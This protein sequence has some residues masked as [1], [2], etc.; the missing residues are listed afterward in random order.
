[1]WGVAKCT[2]M[3]LF[4]YLKQSTATRPVARAGLLR[5]MSLLITYTY[6]VRRRIAVPCCHCQT[7]TDQL[8]KNLHILAVTSLHRTR[9]LTMLVML[10]CNHN[11]SVAAGLHQPIFDPPT[12]TLHLK[13]S[14]LGSQRSLSLD[15]WF[16][17]LV[18][19]CT[20]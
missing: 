2:I 15:A 12:H 14:Q 19:S 3:V 13:L 8:R 5:R 20:M 7:S 1:M 4:C 9:G 16:D 10:A 6:A 17:T 11:N 18:H